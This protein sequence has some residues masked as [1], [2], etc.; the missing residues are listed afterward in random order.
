[1][2]VEIS[3]FDLLSFRL[4]L[5]CGMWILAFLLSLSALYK[6]CLFWPGKLERE[7]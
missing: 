2:L 6:P 4:E 5:L 3:M 7:F 1:M